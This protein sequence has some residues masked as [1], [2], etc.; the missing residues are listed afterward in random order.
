MEGMN[1]I[2]SLILG[3]IVIIIVVALLTGRFS[4]GQLIPF[5]G[6]ATTSPTPTLSARATI[7]P[8]VTPTLGFY[9]NQ[10]AASTVSTTSSTGISNIPQTGPEMFVP[11]TLSLLAAGIY[12]RKK[13]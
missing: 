5:R 3:L 2:F 1:K 4:A 6:K 11:L 13:A 7:S 10:Q 12:L 8:T 9:Q